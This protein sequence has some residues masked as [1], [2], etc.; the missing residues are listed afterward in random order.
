MKLK[1]FAPGK[2]F[3]WVDAAGRKLIDKADTVISV[4]TKTGMIKGNFISQ[5]HY[6]QCKLKQQ[7]PEH[8]KTKQTFSQRCLEFNNN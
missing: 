2:Q 1:D 4:D 3:F 6:T 7:Q 8:L 5:V